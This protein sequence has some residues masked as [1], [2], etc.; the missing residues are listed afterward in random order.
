MKECRDPKAW[1]IE[2]VIKSEWNCRGERDELDECARRFGIDGL[3]YFWPVGGAFQKRKALKINS[4][5][6]A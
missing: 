3:M 2:A 1:K 6:I 5:F 4:D